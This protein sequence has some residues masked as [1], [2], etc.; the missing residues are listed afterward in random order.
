[1]TALDTTTQP[2]PVIRPAAPEEEQLTGPAIWQR[3]VVWVAGWTKLLG[4]SYLSPLVVWLVTRP[5][6]ASALDRH[7]AKGYQGRHRLGEMVAEDEARWLARARGVLCE[8]TGEYPV[9][10]ILQ[11]EAA[12]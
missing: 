2:L 10:A 6:I 12:T 11:T 4:E 3:F 5:R 1:M 9:L 7:A 8:P